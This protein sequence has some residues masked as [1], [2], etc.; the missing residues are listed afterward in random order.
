MIKKITLSI[1]L[2]AALTLVPFVSFSQSWSTISNYGGGA[3]DGA[4]SLIIDGKAYIFG[5]LSTNEVWEYDLTNDSWVQKASIP[6]SGSLTW[7]FGFVVN[8]QAYIVGGDTTGSFAVTDRVQMYDPVAD[9]W[10]EKAAY[11]GGP[12]DGG[13]AF[14]FNGKGYVGGGFNGS[15]L[16]DDFWEYDPANDSWTALSNLPTGPVIFPAYFTIGNKAYIGTGDIGVAETKALWEFD[17]ATKN[18]TQK[19]DLPGAARQAAVGF[20]VNGKGYIG[21]GQSGY[22]ASYDDFYEYDPATDSWTAIASF[23]TINTAWSS[24]FVLGNDAYVGLGVDFPAFSFTSAFYK[25]TL[26][27]VSA[28]EEESVSFNLWPNPSQELVYIENIPLTESRSIQL[29]D[30]NG[31]QIRT[32][33]LEAGQD[34]ATL[35][36][37]DLPDGMYMV[38]VAG[39]S[40]KL[41]KN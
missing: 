40:H 24:A 16:K 27:S 20:S 4:L 31:K 33:P 29:I 6:V 19:S 41:I 2:I 28:P 13:F 23:P 7:P 15:T 22:S 38:E 35:E 14:A 34:K 36:I 12:S 21:G 3:T 9:T 26:S 8:N 30:I 10:A 32:Y 18:W 5:G 39:E 1:R 17:P 11:P 37:S 25:I